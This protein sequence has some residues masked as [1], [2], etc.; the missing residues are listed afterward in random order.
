MIR[1]LIATLLLTSTSALA[2]DISGSR[3]PEG[4]KRYAGSAIVRY[5]QTAFDAYH[6]PLGK[7]MKFDFGTKAAEYEKSEHLEGKI[8]RVTYRVPD[9]QRSS[10][11]VLRNYQNALLAEGWEVLWSA[12]GKGSFGNSFAMAYQSLKGHDQLIPYSDAQGHV[13]VA[14]KDNRTVV[15]FVTKYE[16][17]LTGGVSI[18][19]GDPIV[20]LDLIE[21]AQM[22]EK[23]V[24][25]PASEMAKAIESSGR[26]SLYGIY[27]DFN[28]ADLKAESTPT[29]EQI[30]ALLRESTALKLLVV[31]HTDAVG[32]FEANRELSMRRAQSVVAALTGRYGI[33][34][35]RLSSFGVSFAAPVASN[36]TE[37]GR[38]KNRRVELVE[39]AAG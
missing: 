36:A 1:L 38:A 37:E 28:K 14:R 30:A 22:E 19:K 27:F 11:E 39:V 13:L 26:V 25:I 35:E 32:G 33:P 9:T 12:S 2:Q 20:Q 3:D 5:E 29:L 10:L 8:T 7:M 6:V 23:M 18:D 16:Y 15:L 21:T 17:G 34:P 24:V 4:I 31:G